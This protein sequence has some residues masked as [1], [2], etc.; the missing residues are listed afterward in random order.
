MMMNDNINNDDDNDD[1]EIIDIIH[2]L[3]FSL[4]GITLEL[5][6]TSALH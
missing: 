6:T 3:I 4:P 5:N 2:S 1:D